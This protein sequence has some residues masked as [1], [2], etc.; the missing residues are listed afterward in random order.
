V[1]RRL[2]I[3]VLCALL[4]GCAQTPQADATITLNVAQSTVGAAQVDVQLA[5]AAGQP[6]SG[7][8]V[9]L[10]GD[11]THAGMQ[12]VLT[13]MNDLGNG[14]YRADDFE[15]TMAGDWILTVQAEMPDGTRV[16]RMFDVQGVAN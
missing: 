13:T 15:F 16:E 6:I 8:Q 10:R 9:Q 5:D 3:L 4:V 1:V 2:F 12:P 11:M 14:Q 7:A